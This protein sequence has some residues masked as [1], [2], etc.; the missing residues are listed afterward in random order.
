MFSSLATNLT[1]TGRR[2]GV[3]SIL[4]LSGV[5]LIA[6]LATGCGGGDK[7]KAPAFAPDNSAVIATVGSDNITASYYEDRLAQLAAGELPRKDGMVVDT[8]TDQGKTAFLKILI[9][10]ELL[11]QKAVQLGYDQDPQ[12]Q[13]AR[14]SI[15]EYEGGLK[16]WEDV[17]GDI[18]A[19]IT[20]EELQAFYAQMGTTYQCNYVIC[21]F[22][23]DAMEA[24]AFAQTGADWEDVVDKFHDGNPA[25]SGKYEINVPFGQ[26]SSS[27]EDL[28]FATEKGGVSM[29]IITSYGFWV[30]RVVNILKDKKPSLEEA[31]GRVLDIT[32]N[33][34]QGR[35]RQDFKLGVR[36]KYDFKVN[37][38]ALWAAFQGLPEGGLMDPATDQPYKRED[39]KPLDV[40]S[41]DLG[42]LLYSYK[43]REGKMVE[44]T[45]GAYKISFDK[46]GV[47]Q[48]PKKGD[49]LGGFR[50]KL[51]DEVERGLLNLEAEN[52]GYFEHPE[53]LTKVNLKVE[54]AM[55][56]RLYKEVVTFDDKITPEE[57]DEFWAEHKS[58]YLVE[59]GR[60]GHLVICLNRQKADNARKAIMSGKTWAE[61]LVKFGSDQSNKSKGGKT[62]NIY[63][64]SQSPIVAPLFALEKGEISQPFAV[65]T[66]RF[67]IVQLDNIVL[68]HEYELHEVSEAIG[69]RIRQGRQETA[70][71]ELLG[72]WREEFG[73]EIHTES[74]A[75]L[76]S[77][78]EV[79]AGPDNLVPI[80]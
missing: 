73:V 76:Q 15:T 21:N 61:V 22:E 27:Y 66:D 55:V 53:V 39:L 23:D 80:N 47:F 31:K 7:D 41:E 79:T 75:G 56:T 20:E 45:V 36:E 2:M 52:R 10:K 40:R 67:A 1:A 30:V 63:Q 37:E 24:R 58:D 64:V 54:E 78:E 33:R 77:W 44:Y 72:Q 74:L 49:M 32:K 8:A 38:V 16:M 50:Q 71:L 12:I 26:Y 25:P 65:G 34:K 28:V 9:N 62:E 57:L 13:A 6:L 43:G 69:A 51:I 42:E 68:A 70:F 18:S 60:S 14:K 17:V 19:T 11:A 5:L 48:R 4:I 59:E 29:P 35:L 46:M 3:S